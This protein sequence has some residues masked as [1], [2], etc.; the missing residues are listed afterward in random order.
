MVEG[1]FPELALLVT[2]GHTATT[3]QE[4]DVMVI[5]APGG[6]T[7][8]WQIIVGEETVCHIKQYENGVVYLS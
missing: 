8:Y 2:C 3:Q 7:S 1:S 5:A 4:S 6:R